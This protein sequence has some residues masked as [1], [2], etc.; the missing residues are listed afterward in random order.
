MSDSIKMLYVNGELRHGI[1]AGKT[2]IDT[3][4]YMNDG[5]LTEYNNSD[6]LT[7]Y[8]ILNNP[9]E[10]ERENMSSNNG[11][12]ISVSII[13]GVM[14]VQYKFGCMPWSDCVFE[15]RLYSENLEFPDLDKNEKL[16]LA[17]NILLI[18]PAKGGLVEYLRVIG[19]GHN[20]S[21]SFIEQ[22]NLL[23]LS[24]FNKDLHNMK[25]SRLMN[26]YDTR[27]ILDESKFRWKLGDDGNGNERK[28][29][30]RWNR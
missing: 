23:R 17:L 16:G 24:P 1:E 28:P 19:L 11:F 27:D 5:V 14:F 30:T 18:N 22:C 3:F 6:G 7:L 26:Q 12:E 10:E 21:K 2:K 29:L 9:T 13:E 20:F 4:A 25:V 8:M 15:P